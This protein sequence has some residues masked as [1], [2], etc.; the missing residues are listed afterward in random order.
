MYSVHIVRT[1]EHMSI[2]KLYNVEEDEIVVLDTLMI[3]W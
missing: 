1:L 2:S 3:T